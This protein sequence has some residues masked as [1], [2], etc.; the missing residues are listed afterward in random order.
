MTDNRTTSVVEL[1]REW[2]RSTR[3]NGLGPLGMN[4][5]Q[6]DEIVDIVETELDVEREEAE[7][8]EAQHDFELNMRINAEQ[9]I[10]DVERTHMKLP[11]DADGVPIRPGD[12][13]GYFVDGQKMHVQSVCEKGI[14]YTFSKGEVDGPL[15]TDYLFH[16]KPETVECIIVEAMSLACEPEAP[17]SKN[18]T[19]VKTYAERIRK[20][21][22]DGD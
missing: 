4:L 13:V 18:S 11:V 1:L 8:W 2:V 7:F 3:A 16:V 21:V 22:H 17:Y 5:E 15:P 20:A 14:Y 9:R 6:L 19:L 10:A 12:T